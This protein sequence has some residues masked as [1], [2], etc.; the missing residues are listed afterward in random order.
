VF[1]I[2]VTSIIQNT[3]EKYKILKETQDENA[4]YKKKGKGLGSPLARIYKNNIPRGP[5]Y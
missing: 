1:F 5:I 4:K 3:K 2:F